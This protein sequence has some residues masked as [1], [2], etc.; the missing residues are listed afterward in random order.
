MHAGVNSWWLIVYRFIYQFLH[1][2]LFDLNV[3]ILK[4]LTH[5][6]NLVFTTNPS[7]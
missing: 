1:A 5:F 7:S 3:C 6:F 2:V 4:Y